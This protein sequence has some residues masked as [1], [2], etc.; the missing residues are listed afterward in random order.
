M[1][2]TPQVIVMFVRWIPRPALAIIVI[3][4][5][6]DRRKHMAIRAV[7]FDI[8]GVLELTPE[9][10][11]VGRW[12]E[13]L[14]LGAGGLDERLMDVWVAGSAGTIAEEE[15]ERQLGAILGLDQAALAEFMADL[16]AEYLGTLNAELAAYFAGLRPRYRTGILSNSFAGARRQERERYGFEDMCD[17]VIYSHEEGMKKPDRRFY[18]LACDRLG[19][20]PAEMIFLDDVEACV[21][22]ARELGI[23]AIR[24][25]HTAQAIAAIEAI[26]KG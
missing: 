19:V 23:H 13:R 20:H 4:H 8:G 14:G 26:L 9:T 15:V 6:Y 10:G 24:F 7:V 1:P 17:I 22:A 3:Y 11:W 25:E 18:Q 12:E 21:A 5:R 16:W 2:G